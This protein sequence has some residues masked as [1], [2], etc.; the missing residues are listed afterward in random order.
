[1]DREPRR[2]LTLGH[3]ELRA[4]RSVAAGPCLQG[5]AAT[6]PDWAGLLTA[7]GLALQRAELTCQGHVREVC[8]ETS[9]VKSC[10]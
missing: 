9:A 4:L 2:V 6:H 10:G 3:R 7:A 8:G 5:S 1:M